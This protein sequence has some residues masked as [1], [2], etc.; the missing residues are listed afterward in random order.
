MQN[1]VLCRRWICHIVLFACLFG[2]LGNKGC[3][4]DSSAIV[5]KTRSGYVSGISDGNTTAFL[6]IPFGATTAGANRWKAPQREASWCGIREAKT[7]GPICP[8]KSPYET[9]SDVFSEDCLNLNIWT[10][11]LVPE[12]KMPVMVWL[13]GGGFIFGANSRSFYNG[14]GLARKGVVF[15]SVNYRVNA[16]GFMA[17]EW[18]HAEGGPGANFGLLDQIAALQWVRESI[19]EFGGDPN[20]VTIFGFS[21]GGSSV[22][23]LLSMPMA[24]G[25]FHKAIIMSGVSVSDYYVT[26][27]ITSTW[28]QAATQGANLQRELG[29]NSIDE[30][31]AIDSETILQKC[32]ALEQYFAP[33]MDGY[34]L[35]QPPRTALARMNTADVM[36]GSLANDSVGTMDIPSD[37][38]GYKSG[39][40]KY[41]NAPTNL[42]VE[43]VYTA[44]NDTQATELSVFAFTTA[45]FTEPARF[46]ARQAAANQ[47]KAYRY[48]FQYTP[49]KVEAEGADW[50]Y[51]AF[52]GSELGYVFGYAN[53]NNGYETL[54]EELA[55][56]VQTYW[57]NFAKT[58]TPNGEG[59]QSWPAFDSQ[60][61][62]V[63]ILGR[64]TITTQ[65]GLDEADCDFFEGIYPAVAVDNP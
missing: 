9:A 64:G 25:L 57:T 63:Q 48:Y 40:L 18:F 54:D 32:I 16:F 47:G 6:G 34:S 36:V 62:N 20:N 39:L 51:G 35:T 60:T 8:Q 59:V 56:I 45:A 28:T 31:R 41:F 33:V 2:V 14:A 55:R 37:I 26:G 24:S 5:A 44:T 27:G 13:P 50:P 3:G 22:S 7:M 46:A 30:L 53:K 23:H 49:P 4:T 38:A 58:G 43:A 17:H 29:A 10:P 12:H 65:I 42:S 52:H 1:Y 61:E 11:N 21:A 19:S 15:V